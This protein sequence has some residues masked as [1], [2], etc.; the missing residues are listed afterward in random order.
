MNSFRKLLVIILLALI[1][2]AISVEGLH[3]RTRRTTSSRVISSKGRHTSKLELDLK[4][5]TKA[6][7]IYHAVGLNPDKE[8]GLLVKKYKSALSDSVQWFCLDKE[9]CYVYLR[10]KSKATMFQYQVKTDRGLKLLEITSK[11]LEE[12]WGLEYEEPI[13]FKLNWSSPRVQ[14]CDVG[15]D[16]GVDLN[17]PTDFIHPIPRYTSDDNA[18]I[19]FFKSC[20]TCSIEEEPNDKWIKYT[21]GDEICCSLHDILRYVFGVQGGYKAITTCLSKDKYVYGAT[22]WDESKATIERTSRTDFDYAFTKFVCDEEAIQKLGVDGYYGPNTLHVS[23]AHKANWLVDEMHE[24]M[25]VCDPS[26]KLNYISRLVFTL[27]AIELVV[28]KEQQKCKPVHTYKIKDNK[29]DIILEREDPI[30]IKKD[31]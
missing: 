25:T 23:A 27:N 17:I 5:V 13:C 4:L 10:G 26:K 21:K 24:E 9:S 15:T 18:I 7:P 30:Y 11:N 12:L 2:S 16:K 3:R 31:N 1:S 28:S 29:E 14:I 8:Q 22:D 6:N 19:S 20:A